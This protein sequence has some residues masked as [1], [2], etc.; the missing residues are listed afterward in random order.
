MAFPICDNCARAGHL[1][2]ACQKRARDGKISEL[3]ILASSILAR[4]GA[5][6]FESI[7][8]LEPENKLVMFASEAEARD[9]RK[10]T[11][12]LRSPELPTLRSSSVTYASSSGSSS[13][14]VSSD[15]TQ[16]AESPACAR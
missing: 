14:A 1:C 13:Q 4:H 16:P 12:R 8:E 10:P 15:L 5:T 3:E 6:G 7:V 9:C 2:E 11:N